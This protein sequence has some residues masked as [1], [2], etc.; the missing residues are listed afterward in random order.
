[1]RRHLPP[2][3]P[4]IAFEAVARHLSFS[5]AAD[6]LCVT[7]S[8][9]SHQMRQLEAHFG[10]KLFER[11]NPGLAL[12]E[13][14]EVLLPELREGIE[15]IHA[16]AERLRRR[17][18]AGT[19]TV[20][21]PAGIATLWLVPRLGRFS[22]RHPE[23]EIRLAAVEDAVDFARDGI[24]VALWMKP[25]AEARS[26]PGAVRLLREEIFP[27]CSP[28][29][30]ERLRSPA[31]L[32]GLL[33]LHE[34]HGDVPELDWPVWLERLGV[35]ASPRGL[36]F[37]HFGLAI[38]AAVDGVGVALSRSPLID[39]ELK[40]GRL[41]RPFGDLLMPA[42]RV[43][44][45]EWPVRAKPDPRIVAFTDWLVEESCGCKLAAGP[46]GLPPVAAPRAAAE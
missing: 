8:A 35:A 26:G 14:G 32:A 4:L 16:A 40:A 15:R 31:D 18:R 43:Y 12:T 7:Q 22:A 39:A 1:M 23:I 38:R 2:L 5:K 41:V 3:Q 36:R 25:E 29:V 28:A 11:R 19:L 20:A 30:A 21:A 45:A 27:V 6:E 24:D 17:N 13:A 33:L 46:C 34:D 42:S 10:E 44:T 9:V 37:S